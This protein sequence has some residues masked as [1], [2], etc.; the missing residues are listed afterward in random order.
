[1]KHFNEEETYKNTFTYIHCK[2]LLVSSKYND[3]PVVRCQIVHA[4][5]KCQKHY[6]MVHQT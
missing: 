5:V 4:Y 1:M 6:F 3:R 2:Q